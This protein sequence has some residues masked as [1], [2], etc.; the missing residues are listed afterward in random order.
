MH[1]TTIAHAAK[2]SKPSK[3]C[4]Q[5]E[6]KVVELKGI[7]QEVVF[8]GPPNYES[9]ET[10]DTPEHSL[11]L[12]LKDPICV[13]GDPSSDMNSETVRDIKQVQVA[14]VTYKKSVQ[15]M[16]GKNITVRGTLFAAHT[17]HHRTPVLIDAKDIK[18]TK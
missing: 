14:L 10:G 7:L 6:P 16:I 1:S 11:I 4:L 8:P 3:P 17:G 9:V 18:S 5:Y 13:Q 15:K 12:Q 2:Y